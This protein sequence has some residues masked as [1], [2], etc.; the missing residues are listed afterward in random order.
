MLDI[1]KITPY[2]K[3]LNSNQE[4][5]VNLA[6]IFEIY[7]CINEN[8]A[9]FFGIDFFPQGRQLFWVRFPDSADRLATIRQF[10]ENNQLKVTI[11]QCLPF[12]D[13]GVQEAFRLQMNRRT[14]GKIVV[15]MVPNADKV[16]G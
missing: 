8:G 11:A 3:I 5:A 13:E 2:I 10:C 12:T 4:S 14:V 16:E 9:H 1:I 7:F 15:E 6:V